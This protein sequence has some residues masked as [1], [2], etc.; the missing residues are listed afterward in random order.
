MKNLKEIKTTI[1]GLV[2]M[3][4]G[5]AYTT[6]SPSPPYAPTSMIPT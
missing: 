3:A 1:L 5:G 6:L 2:F 4:V